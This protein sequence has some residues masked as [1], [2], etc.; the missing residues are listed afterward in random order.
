[1][2]FPHRWFRLA[3]VFGI[4]AVSFRFAIDNAASRTLCCSYAAFEVVSHAMDRILL[5]PLTLILLCIL[6]LGSFCVA[7]RAIL[8]LVRRRPR[9]QSFLVDLLF[10]L[11]VPLAFYLAWTAAMGHAEVWWAKGFR[12][13]LI[14]VTLLWI[15]TLVAT[16]RQSPRTKVRVLLFFFGAISMIAIPA[17]MVNAH[18]EGYIIGGEVL[19]EEHAASTQYGFAVLIACLFWAADV[20]ISFSPH[21]PPST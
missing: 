14:A 12:E 2:S 20:L 8:P 17:M 7:A 4:F 3:I 19:F 15:A 6:A 5:G 21:P 9:S 11:G 13:G 1:M 16:R 18:P 10:A